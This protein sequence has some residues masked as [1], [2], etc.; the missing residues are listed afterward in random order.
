MSIYILIINLKLLIAFQCS[1]RTSKEA[2]III[3][4]NENI[5]NSL[6][7]RQKKCFEL[8]LK[9]DLHPLPTFS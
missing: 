9:Q 8:S 5:T 3:E 2:L 4:Q 1:Y 6:M 7:G